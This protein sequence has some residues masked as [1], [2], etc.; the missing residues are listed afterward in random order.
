MMYTSTHKYARISPTKVRRIAILMAGKSYEEVMAYL[1]HLPHAGAK[2][3]RAVAHTAA[4]NALSANSALD[5]SSLIVS[6]VIINEG[7]RMKRMWPRARGR[8]DV[9]LKRFSHITVSLTDEALS[10]R[11]ATARGKK[12]D[13]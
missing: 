10:K 13:R 6:S 2:L 7:P 5:E 9:L 12:G 1:K 8:A 3:M 4:A 11:G